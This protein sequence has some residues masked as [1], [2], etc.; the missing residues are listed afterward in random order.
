MSHEHVFN[1][2]GHESGICSWGWQLGFAHP[3]SSNHT[4]EAVAQLHSR[5][6]GRLLAF[7]P[8]QPVSVFTLTNESGLRVSG[9][10]QFDRTFADPTKLAVAEVKVRNPVMSMLFFSSQV[11]DGYSLHIRIAGTERDTAH[12]VLTRSS[13]R[14]PS[15]SHCS[16]NWMGSDYITGGISS[17]AAKQMQTLFALGPLLVTNGR[18]RTVFSVTNAAGKVYAGQFE[19]RGPDYVP[20]VASA[21]PTPPRPGTLAPL[22]L[23]LSLPPLPPT[24]LGSDSARPMRMPMPPAFEPPKLSTPE[25]LA[26]MAKL[27]EHYNQTTNL[28]V[29]G[30]TVSTTLRTN[31]PAFVSTNQFEI[32]LGRPSYYFVHWI[33]SPVGS[34]VNQGA[35]W[36]DG[37]GDW[38]TMNRSAPVK[39]ADRGMAL[40]GA[41]GVS[42]YVS[43]WLPSLFFGNAAWLQVLG[44]LRVEP[45][46]VIQAESCTVLVGS[47]RDNPTRLWIS[48]QDFLLR[49]AEFLSTVRTDPANGFPPGG[50]PVGTTI[51]TVQTYRRVTTGQTLTPADFKF[52]PPDK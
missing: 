12:S 20:P 1:Q 31:Q 46:A 24:N 2:G 15:D 21:A 9:E 40:G 51:R 8:G 7:P 33:S 38:F 5:W 52:T 36:S 3:F 13:S 26:L 32:K 47:F 25:G 43:T 4:D 30:F 22:P 6:D 48:K 45:D 35:A 23:P 28:V 39:N 10:V 19:L 27:R 41:G 44:D 18:P 29:E 11:P 42:K 16:W 17:L 34:H 37:T 50:F 49:Q 14:F